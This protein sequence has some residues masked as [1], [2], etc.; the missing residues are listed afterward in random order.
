MSVINKCQIEIEEREYRFELPFFEIELWDEFLFT[1]R[2]E[3]Y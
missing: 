1:C 2:R 3:M